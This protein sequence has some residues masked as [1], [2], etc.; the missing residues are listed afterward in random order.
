MSG[1]V[2]KLFSDPSWYLAHDYYLKTR[3]RVVREIIVPEGRRRML[4]V[5]CGDG[6]MSLAVLQAGDHLTM[7]DSS[8]KMLERAEENIRR[9]QMPEG[10]TAQ[11]VRADIRDLPKNEGYDLVMAL[12][13]LAHASDPYGILGDL[14]GMVRPGGA[15]VVQITD[16]STL[17]GRFLWTYD[18][19]KEK[20]GRRRGYRLARLCA[21]SLVQV[22]E[23]QGLSL[24]SERRFGFD[25][26]GLRRLLPDSWMESIQNACIDSSMLNRLTSDRVMRF[27]RSG[28]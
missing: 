19:V 7:V 13:V 26:P 16:C 22:C 15:L 9:F 20:A 27:A 1:P 5:G 14:A 17:L 28:R 25:P 12:G 4:D 3:V 21:D 11:T 2:E 6:R 24:S 23:K 8:A 18:A 10:A